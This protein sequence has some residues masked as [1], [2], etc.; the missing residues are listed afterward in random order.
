MTKKILLVDDSK[1]AR[2]L[3]KMCLS[4]HNDYELL[5]TGDWQEALELAQKEAP[6]LIVLDYNMPEKSGAE[7]A[8]M[9]QQKGIH[10]HYALVSANTQNS[11][12]DEVKQLGFFDILEKPVTAE[13]VEAML[14]KIT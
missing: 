10:S 12:I 14:E 11:V 2:M 5:S 8:S 6:F 13:S 4:G 9:M 1:T 3:F 7:L